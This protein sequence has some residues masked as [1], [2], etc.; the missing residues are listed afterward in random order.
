MKKNLLL[1][2]LEKEP[3]TSCVDAAATGSKRRRCGD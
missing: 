1:L 2:V 3:I